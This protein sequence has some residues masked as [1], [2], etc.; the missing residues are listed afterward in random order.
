MLNAIHLTGEC[1]EA[2][3]W[4][5]V[6]AIETLAKDLKEGRVKVAALNR[7][8]FL[9]AIADQVVTGIGV[10]HCAGMQTAHAVRR[11]DTSNWS[12][13]IDGQPVFDANG[14]IAKPDSYQPP[15]LEGLY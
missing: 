6:Q 8:E 3:Y 13:F 9:D 12:K 10:G 14:K 11:V 15:N 4:A 7:K 1:S 5:A 2:I